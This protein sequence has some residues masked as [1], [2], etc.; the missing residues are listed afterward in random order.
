MFSLKPDFTHVEHFQW[1]PTVAEKRLVFSLSIHQ[2]FIAG[3]SRLLDRNWF[4]L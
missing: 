1:N 2:S 4:F 3:W